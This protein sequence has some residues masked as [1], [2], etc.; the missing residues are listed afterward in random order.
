MQIDECTCE[1]C[2]RSAPATKWE[3]FGEWR[4]CRI[5]APDCDNGPVPVTANYWC[6]QGLWRDPNGRI[7]TWEQVVRGDSRERGDEEKGGF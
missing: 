7:W 1:T 3:R 6:C 5:L 2:L 4:E